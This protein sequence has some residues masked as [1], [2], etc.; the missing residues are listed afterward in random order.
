MRDR[1]ER[2]Y[3][4]VRIESAHFTRHNKPTTTGSFL[5][6]TDNRTK[7]LFIFVCS[8]KFYYF[9]LFD[10]YLQSYYLFI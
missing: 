7:R 4:N 9:N 2:I 3:A 5:F 10:L 8:F 6:T 1:I